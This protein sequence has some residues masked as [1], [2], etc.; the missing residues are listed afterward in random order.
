MYLAS[1]CFFCVSS[2]TGISDLCLVYNKPAA[3]IISPVGDFPTFK[4]NF[5]FLTKKHFSLIDKKYLSLSEIFSYGLG[6][7]FE[8]KNYKDK[9]VELKNHSPE[10][11]KLCL[12]T[13]GNNY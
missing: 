4:K 5:I 6:F 12:R 10:E 9:K 7:A 2:S 1:K 3:M 8:T 13:R 11:I